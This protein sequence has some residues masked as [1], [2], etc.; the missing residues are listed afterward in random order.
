MIN[1]TPGRYEQAVTEAQ[2]AIDLDPDFWTGYYNLGV[3]NVYL[4]RFSEAEDALR[5]ARARGLDADELLMLAYDISFLEGDAAGMRREADAA[6][7]RPGGENWMSARESFVAAYS[8]RLSDAR[9][10]SRR[11][12]EQA[13]QASQPERAALWA[14]GSGIREALFGDRAAA[15]GAA[16][17]ALQ[18]SHD[19]EVEYG[20]ALALALS[21]DSSRAQLLA[22]DLQRRSAESTAVKFSYLPV[23]RALVALDRNDTQSALD[24]LQ[25]AAPHELG[26]PLSSISGLFGAVY[27]AYVRGLALLD[28]HRATDAAAEF[29]KV[30]DHRGIVT[31]DPIGALARLQLARAYAMNGNTGRAQAG[32]R[33]FL[34]LWKDADRQ[35]P[36]LQQAQREYAR[37]Q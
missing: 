18:L 6:R 25:T 21:G 7:A 2:R 24:S 17:A 1:K 3:N 5:R 9:M 4:G 29:Q 32:Y 36:V 37:L 35:I 8:G 19:R 16:L 15:A 12:V 34:D 26:V 22:D 28:A 13:V 10:L 20:A 27:P 11:A 30:L 33:D 31:T 23:L 14:A